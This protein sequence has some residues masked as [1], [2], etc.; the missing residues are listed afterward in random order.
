MLLYTYEIVI[1]YG[2]I[3][4]PLKSKHISTLLVLERKI[5]TFGPVKDNITGERKRRKDKEL[6][7]TFGEIKN[8]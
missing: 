4:W 1:L 5:F 7:I 6:H 8:L 3:I 2:S